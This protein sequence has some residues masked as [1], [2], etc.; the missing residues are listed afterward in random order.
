MQSRAARGE[1]RRQRCRGRGIAPRPRAV[2][3]APTMLKAAG[4]RRQEVAMQTLR[5]FFRFAVQ[6]IRYAGQFLLSVLRLF[7]LARRIKA[8]TAAWEQLPGQSAPVTGA[9]GL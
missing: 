1:V 5:A 8:N 2:A 6:V 7:R 9:A 4:A 3:V